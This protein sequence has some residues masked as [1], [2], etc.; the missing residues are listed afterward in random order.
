ME[1]PPGN[2]VDQTLLG[3][4]VFNGLP[5]QVAACVAEMTVHKGLA[6]SFLL[7]VQN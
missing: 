3:L 6:P 1:V 5:D 4:P 2:G 7:D